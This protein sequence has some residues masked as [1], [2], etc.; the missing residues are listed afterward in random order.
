VIP[1]AAPD[2]AVLTGQLL[3]TTTNA[4][5]SSRAVRLAPVYR[6]APGSADGAYVLDEA[7]SPA[8]TTNAEGVFVFT[9]LE[10]AEY[11]LMITIAEGQHELVT[12]PSGKPKVWQADSGKVT[13]LGEV[14]VDWAP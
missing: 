14:R 4:P 2:R 6:A 10:A 1:T 8:A 11:V 7:R 12:E 3:S 5:I 9:D 13:N